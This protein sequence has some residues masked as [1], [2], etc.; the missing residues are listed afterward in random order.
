LD[1]TEPPKIYVIRNAKLLPKWKPVTASIFRIAGT[2]IESLIRTQGL[3]DLYQIYF[4][5]Q[6]DGGE[7]YLAYIP[8]DFEEVSDELFDSAYM[9]V[10]Y[11]LGYEMAKAGYPWQRLP[12]GADEIAL[13]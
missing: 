6:R 9:N 5:T 12:P 11:D 4:L 13:E 8:D 10:L 3:G 7:Y 1:V 2:S